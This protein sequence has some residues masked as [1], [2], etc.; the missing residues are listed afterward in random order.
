MFGIEKSRS[1]TRFLNLRLCDELFGGKYRDELSIVTCYFSWFGYKIPSCR[2]HFEK[3]TYS[4]VG[5]LNSK[6]L[7]VKIFSS[8]S[9][10]LKMLP[11]FC[12]LKWTTKHL[13]KINS[14]PRELYRQRM[15]RRY[16]KNCYIFKYGILQLQKIL[17]FWN[18]DYR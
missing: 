8:D 17:H 12:V 16:W 15:V 14:T 9:F 18:R 13:D 1:R 7:W 6:S 4:L 3:I 5:I 11:I 10:L 2:F